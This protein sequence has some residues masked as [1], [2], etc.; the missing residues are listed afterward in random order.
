MGKILVT[1]S[2]KDP[3]KILLDNIENLYKIQFDNSDNSDNSDNFKICIVDSDSTNFEM[4]DLIKEKYPNV[5]IHFAKNKNYEYGAYKYAFGLYPDYDIYLCIQDSIIIKEKINLNIINDYNCYLLEGAEGFKYHLSIINTAAEL[6]KNCDPKYKDRLNTSF[7]LATYCT[8][9]VS[10][11]NMENIFKTLIH[12]PINKDGSCCYERLFGLYFV[13]N[14][15]KIINFV[16][17]VSKHH[18]F[19]Q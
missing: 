18:R 19:R 6:L 4:Y 1:I 9:I 13:L 8:F 5:E 2:S 11:K 10:N 7:A 3:T 15:I 17:N 16:K 12:P 14:N